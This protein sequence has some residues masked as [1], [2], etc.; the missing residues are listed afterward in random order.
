MQ[1]DLRSFMLLYLEDTGKAWE[2]HEA[3]LSVFVETIWEL[4]AERS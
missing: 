2:E 3:T 4:Q 1:I